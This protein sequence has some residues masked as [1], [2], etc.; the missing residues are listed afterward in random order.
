MN[1]RV[2]IRTAGWG[3]PLLADLVCVLVF[4]TGGKNT[5]EAGD[6]DW[7]V[8]VI[9]W[10]FALAAVLAHLVLLA[11]G[12]AARE[13]RPAGMVVVATTYVLG[14]AL[15]VVAGRG[16][17][18]GFLIVAAFF[19]TV[20]MLGWRMIAGRMWGDRSAHERLHSARVRRPR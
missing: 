4:A 16:V 10:P 11:Q 6:S 19:L 3:L 12:R 14:M 18:A 2:S 15:R 13:W 17:A 8:L 1:A 9:A 20:T 7:T 5:H